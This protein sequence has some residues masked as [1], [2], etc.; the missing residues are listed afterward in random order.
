MSSSLARSR[1]NTFSSLE[2]E[3]D[4]DWRSDTATI[5][6]RLR[7]DAARFLLLRDDGR[8]LVAAHR[9]S[10]RGL[11]RSEFVRRGGTELATTYIDR[12]ERHAGA[13]QIGERTAEF[14]RSSTEIGRA[15][16]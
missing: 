9:Q 16:V 10:L 5:N 14:G 11:D 3:R 7:N 15:H 13:A 4:A 1:N 8:A 12:V 2:I 6:A